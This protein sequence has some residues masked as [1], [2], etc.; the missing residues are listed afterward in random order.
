MEATGYSETLVPFN[1]TT[2]IDVPGDHT[3]SN[4]SKDIYDHVIIHS[5]VNGMSCVR[6]STQKSALATL[7][8]RKIVSVNVASLNDETKYCAL[9]I[10][11]LEPSG[12]Y[13]YHQP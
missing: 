6:Y 9:L 13:M 7:H 10:N 5:F 3:S 1:Q 12:Y 4:V 8:S 2:R 11:P